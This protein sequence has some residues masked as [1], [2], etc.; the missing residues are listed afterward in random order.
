MTEETIQLE[1]QRCLEV[2]TSELDVTDAVR[3]S[4][5]PRWSVHCFLAGGRPQGRRHWRPASRLRALTAIAGQD[6]TWHAIDGQKGASKAMDC[7]QSDGDQKIK[8]RDFC[9]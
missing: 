3:R 1:S 6:P 5:L 9:T 2:S 8:T 7:R 4:V